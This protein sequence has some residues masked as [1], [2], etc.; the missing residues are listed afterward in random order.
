MSPRSLSDQQILSQIVRLTRHERSLTLAVLLHL[1]EIERRRLHLTQ[2]YGSMFDYCTSGLGY[3]ASATSRRLRVARCVA[4]FPDIYPLLESNEVNVS[5]VAQVSRIL[6]AGNK[7]A[8]LA[9]IRGKSQR[10]VEAIVAEY[11]PRAAMPRDRIRSVVVRVPVAP[12]PVAPAL[13]PDQDSWPRA[14]EPAALEG[15]SGKEPEAC[16]NQITDATGARVLHASSLPTPSDEHDRNRRALAPGERAPTASE[17]TGGTTQFEKRALVQFCASAEFM[18]LYEKLR[19]LKWHRLP[20]NP[21]MEDV[22]SLALEYVLERE[23]P[24]RRR[25]RRSKRPVSSAAAA[26]AK[27]SPARE[28]PRCVSAK[29]RDEIFARDEGRCTFVGSTGRR[30]G[31]TQALQVDHIVPIARGGNGTTGNLRLLCAYHNRL[32]AGRILGTAACRK[33]AATPVPRVTGIEAR[34]FRFR[35]QCPES[36][37]L[38]P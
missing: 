6:T 1:N 31:S 14:V 23:D 4:R 20:V 12:S 38:R 8:V 29:V 21:S 37:R 24:K 15:T 33:G 2:G 35:Y 11:E 17:P 28:N 34:P 9:R 22:L 3:S 19:S 26:G 27:I 7:A 18:A 32:E 25:A 10:E 5:T 16:G 36:S 13:V 30:C